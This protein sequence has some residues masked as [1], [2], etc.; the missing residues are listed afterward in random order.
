MAKHGILDEVI[1]NTHTKNKT[2]HIAV[3]IVSI[4]VYIVPAILIYF[5]VG[6]GDIWGLVGS[7]T[8][9]GFLVAYLLI[10]IAGP[11]FLHRQNKLKLKNIIISILGGISVLV[12]FIGSI[13]PI[14]D[15]PN[16]LLI[17]IFTILLAAGFIKFLWQRKKNPNIVS[18]IKKQIANKYDGYEEDRNEQLKDKYETAQSI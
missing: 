7:I 10:D 6:L 18:N 5:N 4:I 14:P 3:G 12:P 11:V 17:Y 16:N 1:S 15:F 13:Y 9:F 8:T 2:P